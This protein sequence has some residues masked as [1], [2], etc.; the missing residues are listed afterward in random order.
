MLRLLICL[1]A[2]FSNSTQGEEIKSF[3]YAV[4]WGYENSVKQVIMELTEKI[5]HPTNNEERIA[6]IL[7]A[8][9]LKIQQLAKEVA[10]HI[11]AS[12]PHAPAIID[13]GMF[14]Q[15]MA[16]LNATVAI[17]KP[18][19]PH[20][21]TIV[22]TEDIKSDKWA[23]AAHAIRSITQKQF[24]F[25]TKHY[26]GEMHTRPQIYKAFMDAKHARNKVAAITLRRAKASGISATKIDL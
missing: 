18:C 5:R 16:G 1:V 2:L 21:Y 14:T 3:E 26:L 22:K 23:L 12:S 10:N 4:T 6:A 24:N 17:G 8:G 15:L 7:I 19:L 20:L 13:N 25:Y 11:D 9:N